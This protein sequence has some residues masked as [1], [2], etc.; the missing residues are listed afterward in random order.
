MKKFTITESLTVASK[1]GA[2]TFH[3][4]N[5]RDMTEEPLDATPVSKLTYNEVMKLNGNHVLFGMIEV[6]EQA[7]WLLP[8]WYDRNEVTY[9]FEARDS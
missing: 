8:E 5:V 4:S 7:G 1:H 6:L 3:T 2:V 9:S